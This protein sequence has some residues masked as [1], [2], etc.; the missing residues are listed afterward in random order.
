MTN[1]SATIPVKFVGAANAELEAQGFGPLNF[2]VPAQ[3]VGAPG[4]DFAGL[5]CWPHPAFRAAV[6]ALDPAY[7]VVIT[8]GQG[9]P[10]F[11][12]ACTARAIEWKPYNGDNAALPMK[13]ATTVYEGKTWTNLA[14]RN[15][16]AP[17]VNWRAQGTNPAWS[18]PVGKEDAYPLAFT[19]THKAKVWESLIAFNVG[20]PGVSGWRE[21]VATGYPAWVQPTGGHDAYKLQAKVIHKG[22][23]WDNTGSDA[24]VWEPGV[25]GWVKIA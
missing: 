23:N 18:Q 4:A 7:G 19:V 11:D 10:N 21:V 3:T 17:P 9:Q 22:F 8:D 15:A 1:F 13:G 20:V 2:S 25:F 6:E 5:H 16:F 14:D 12:K 24:N